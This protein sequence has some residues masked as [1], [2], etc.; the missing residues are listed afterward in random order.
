MTLASLARSCWNLVAGSQPVRRPAPRRLELE[1]LEERELPATILGSAFIDRG[2]LGVQSPT[3]TLVS[4]AVITLTG[5]TNTGGSVQQQ[6][7]TDAGGVFRFDNLQAG[8]YQLTGPASLVPSAGQPTYKVSPNTVVD[9][10]FGF[11]GLAPGVISLRQFLNSTTPSDY[12]VNVAIAGSTQSPINIDTSA[13]L[14][15]NLAALGFNYSL[16]L[17]Q[18]FFQS[19]TKLEV[20]FDAAARANNFIV[21][22]DGRVFYL[23]QFHFH[24]TSEHTIDGRSFG[25]ELHMVHMDAAGNILVVGILLEADDAA[26]IPAAYNTLLMNLPPSGGETHVDINASGLLPASSQFYAYT[27]SLTTSPFTEGVR[28]RVMA[29]TVKLPSTSIQMIADAI[30]MNNNRP[31]QPLNGRQVILDVN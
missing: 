18:I 10:G 17:N 20:E 19:G 13:V 31:I 8:T 16:A 2:V 11:L 24:T 6:V 27:G 15:Q 5:I 14:R 12:P 28:W 29:Q 26:P 22:I 9:Q 4:N 3:E 1:S 30:G 21:D 7:T 25:G 23:N